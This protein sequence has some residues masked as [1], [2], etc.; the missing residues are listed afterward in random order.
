MTEPDETLA[1]RQQRLLVR[2]SELR[3][4]FALHAQVWRQPLALADQ[5]HSAWRWLRAHPELPLAA[6]AFVLLLRPRRSL[7][8]LWRLGWRLWAGWRL[9]QRAQVRLAPL[10]ITRRR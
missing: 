1:Q 10:L 4:E 6:V 5:V 2:S 3:G 8:L 9:W 7:G